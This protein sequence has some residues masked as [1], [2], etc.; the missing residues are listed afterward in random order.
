[1]N[2]FFRQIFPYQPFQQDP[3]Y[4]FGNVIGETFFQ[5]HLPGAG[6]RIGRHGYE[7]NIFYTFHL[8]GAVQGFNTVHPRHHLIQQNQ[9]KTLFSQPVQA[10]L[11]AFAQ[12]HLHFSSL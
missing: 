11:S 4:W 10:F 1:M 7:R 6:H 5:E 3:V 8:P 12:L 9:I 2:L